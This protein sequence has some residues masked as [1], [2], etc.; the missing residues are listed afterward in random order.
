MDINTLNERMNLSAV[1]GLKDLKLT[2]DEAAQLV[3][4]FTDLNNNNTQ[5]RD[6]II[7]LQTDI[8]QKVLTI[9]IPTA[10]MEDGP[11]EADGGTF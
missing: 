4:I 9:S 11:I 10:T 8:I 1:R 5:L 3:K 6:Q 2:T 7:T